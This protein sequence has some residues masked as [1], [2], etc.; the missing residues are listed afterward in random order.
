MLSQNIFIDGSDLDN[1][2]INS[3]FFRLPKKNRMMLKGVVC[4]PQSILIKNAAVYICQ[5]IKLDEKEVI[6]KEYTTFTNELGEYGISVEIVKN[7]YYVIK[8]FC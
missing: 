6:L 8:A 2:K 1:N 4:G 7:S 3:V 5:V